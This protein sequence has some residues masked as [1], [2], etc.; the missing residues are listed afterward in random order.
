VSVR[1]SRPALVVRAL[2]AL[3]VGVSGAVALTATPATA[4]ESS[5][6]ATTEAL[7][8]QT[9]LSRPMPLDEAL[10]GIIGR[11]LVEAINH[12]TGAQLHHMAEDE[13]S[14]IDE[15]GHIFVADEPVP[16][17]QQADTTQVAAGQVPA[18]VFNLSSR[19]QSTRTIYLDFDG[20]TYSGTRWRNG[21]TIVSPAYS[22][23]S[24]PTTF[25]EEERAQ[26]YL[27]WRVVSEDFAPFDVNVTTR[28]PAASALSRTSSADQTYGFPVVITP[29]NSVGTSCAC[30][31]LSYV[32]MF[33]GVNAT[34]Y[35]PAWAFTNGSGTNGTNIGQVVSHELGHTFGLSHDGTSSA[36]YYTGDKGW[37]PIMGASYGKRAS[38]WSSGEYAD[39]NNT[40]DDVA[41][42]A[43]TAPLV[44]DDHANSVLGATAIEVGSTTAGL[45]GSRSDVDAFTFTAGGPV[46]LS[47]AGPSEVSDTDL[48]VTIQNSLGL[49]V[50]TIDPAADYASD[51]S[52]DAV[53]SANLPATPETYTALVEGVGNGNP[54][55]AG[56][57]SD[58][59]SLGRYE[60]SL[61]AG[62]VTTTPPTT[63]TTS[64]TGTTRPTSTVE[65]A[66]SKAVR[67]VE[68][69]TR[70]LP[71]AKVGK[72]Y[73][74]VIRFSGPVTEARL[75]WHLPSGLKWRQ[76]GAAIV[77]TGKLKARTSARFTAFI[78]SAD[79]TAKM[80]YRLVAR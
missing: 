30:G 26:I 24:D 41:I 70:S 53:W 16:A 38:Q 1:S 6:S 19:P 13:T 52:M 66:D 45:I 3:V 57:Y 21:E 11:A 74:A 80:K 37:A 9:P 17:A 36:A 68:F 55:E 69:L 54:L 31:G 75:D 7:C 22:L 12:L 63:T 67:D 32:G 14:W 48:R 65:G 15:C 78:D 42:I 27:A 51:A 4:A 49:T 10:T 60:V 40:E 71:K 2:V 58:Y 18:D 73:R 61:S 29:T 62:L 44:A 25:N 8:V 59:G 20:A 50:A 47:V 33:G 34:D 77:I 28:Q 35:Q 43:R 46:T 5:A 39:A 76:S 56:R 72:K 64:T 23:D 79:A